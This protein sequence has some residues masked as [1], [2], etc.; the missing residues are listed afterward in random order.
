MGK[1]LAEQLREAIRASSLSLT[2]L[3]RD[4]GIDSGRLSRFMR[5]ERDLT[6][7]ATAALCAALGLELAASSDAGGS[8]GG[9]RKSGVAKRFRPRKAK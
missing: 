1:H 5:G 7:D 4:T 8:S 3:G 6:L 9:V 2:Q